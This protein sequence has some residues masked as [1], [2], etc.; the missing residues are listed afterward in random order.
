MSEAGGASAAPD[1]TGPAGSGSSAQPAPPAPRRG[2]FHPVAFGVLFGLTAGVLIAVNAIAPTR[3]AAPTPPTATPAQPGPAAQAVRWRMASAFPGTLV[4]LG[5][6][7]KRLAETLARISAGT[8]AIDFAEPGAPTA[9]A[10][11]FSAVK[12][13]AVEAG[14]S[15][16]AYWS[17]EIPAAAFFAAV[18][19]GPAAG[20]YLAWMRFGGGQEIHDRI[21]ER[22]GVKGIVCAIAAPEASGWFRKE[23][24]SVA[25]LAGLKM[26]FYGLGGRVM[27]K[28]G[29]TTRLPAGDVFPALEAGTVD[30]LEYSMPA[31]DVA[32][33]FDEIAK[34][35]YF[36]GWHQQSTIVELIVN[37]DKWR[38]LEDIQRAWIEAACGDNVQHT[39]A[40]GEAIQHAALADLSARGVQIHRWP[41]PM[42]AAFRAAWTEVADEVGAEDADFRQARQSLRTFRDA[43]AAWRRLGYL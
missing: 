10:E 31:I 34:H 1:G 43:G 7:G 41:A 29:V 24:G 38:G 6:S 28:L 22:N 32:L 23:I 33:G 36:P 13:G 11:V 12:S 27:R 5:T 18:P 37:L 14:W 40:E 15:L 16:A 2:L 20:E 17:D 19:F 39:L 3:P 9:A 8:I 42:L 30:A 26:R 25:E 35:Y 4:Q 21:Y